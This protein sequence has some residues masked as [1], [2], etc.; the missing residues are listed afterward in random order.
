MEFVKK[1]IDERAQHK[2]EYV[3]RMNKIQMQL[4]KR[5]VDSSEALDASLV[6]TEFNGIKSDKQ[7]TSSSSGNYLTYAIDAYIR[8]LIYQV[9]FSKVQLA[10]QHNVLAN[11]Q[12]HSMQ[13]KFIYDTQLLEKVDTNTTPGSTN[14]CHMGGEIDQN[15][16]KL[17]QNS[18]SPTPYVPPSKKDYGILFQPLL[19]EYFNPPP[20]A[21]SLDLT[22]VAAPKVV[23]PAGLV[24]NSVSP[25][26]YVPP[27]KKD[28][29]ILFQP[30]F[31]EYFNP[32][33]R[34]VSPDPTAVAAPK[35]VDPA[36]SPS[37]TTITIC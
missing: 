23:D 20:R 25:T 15:A 12:Q 28:Y 4:K 11:E 14:M 31:D 22:A 17:V 9:P 37:S 21:V 33:P 26:P 19:D 1:S 35:A 5:K 30:L 8:P 3:G 10:T 13:S 34:A 36:G 6:V 27:S 7:V 16:E 29:E 32:L 2:R 18:V 24:Q